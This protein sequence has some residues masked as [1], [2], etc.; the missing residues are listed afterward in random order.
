MLLMVCV[1]EADIVL[2]IRSRRDPVCG[3]CVGVCVRGGER[4]EE[5]GEGGV[6]GKWEGMNEMGRIGGGGREWSSIVPLRAGGRERE[7]MGR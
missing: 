3:V 5:R 6:V 1:T 7:R 2:V 4:R